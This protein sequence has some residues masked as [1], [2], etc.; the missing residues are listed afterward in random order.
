MNEPFSNIL[1]NGSDIGVTLEIWREIHTQTHTHKNRDIDE[2]GRKL[3][4]SKHMHIQNEPAIF[5]AS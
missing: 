3:T 2:E 1:N 5:P 4:L